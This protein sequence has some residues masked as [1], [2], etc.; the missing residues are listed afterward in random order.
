[1]FGFIIIRYKSIFF[2]FIFAKHIFLGKLSNYVVLDTLIN[3]SM[4]Q[5]I[6]QVTRLCLT[7][8]IGLTRQYMRRCSNLAPTCLL[9][10]KIQYFITNYSRFMTGYFHLTSVLFW[11]YTNSCR[12]S[13]SLSPSI[14]PSLSLSSSPSHTHTIVT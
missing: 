4:K 7:D 8:N 6:K 2:Y 11:C 9:Y 1:M 12:Q 13:H 10:L 5:I 3:C 14:S